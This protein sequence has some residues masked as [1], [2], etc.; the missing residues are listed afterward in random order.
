MND[1]SYDDSKAII[2]SFQDPRIH[3]IQN[4]GKGILPALQTAQKYIKGDYVTRMDSDDIMPKDKLDALL[5]ILENE[6]KGVIATGSVKYF[7]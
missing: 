6:P 7:R 3:F 2:E 4:E 1:H 5:K